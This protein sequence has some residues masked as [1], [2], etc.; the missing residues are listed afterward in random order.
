[1]SMLIT[2]P[3]WKIKFLTSA[4]CNIYPLESGYLKEF[5]FWRYI[6]IKI[7][8]VVWSYCPL[9][10][11]DFFLRAKNSPLLYVFEES[12]S[13]GESLCTCELY[14]D[15]VSFLV[16]CLCSFGW[17]GW[18]VCVC[19]IAASPELRE[20]FGVDSNGS[21]SSFILIFFSNQ[22]CCLPRDTQNPQYRISGIFSEF[23]STLKIIAFSSLLCFASFC[24]SDTNTS[25]ITTLIKY[26]YFIG[27]WNLSTSGTELC[28]VWSGV[29]LNMLCMCSFA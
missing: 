28:S 19:A 29:L 12:I 24:T 9:D 7:Y 6:G 23:L 21:T 17:V 22:K 13:P 15:A 4:S 10:P 27:K 11:I 25:K 16:Q 3:E 26:G 2:S 20:K 5:L 8:G 18:L 1:M 14:C